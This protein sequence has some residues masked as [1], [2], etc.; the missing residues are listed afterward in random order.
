M[1][2]LV[3]GRNENVGAWIAVG[4]LGSV[5]AVISSYK[6]KFISKK[7]L[8]AFVLLFVWLASAVVGLGI[9]KQHIYDHYFG[10]FFPVPFLI[11]GGVFQL[12]LN[13]AFI[14]GWWVVGTAL[15]YLVYFN[16]ADSPLRYQP[17]RQLQRS[18][19]VAEFVNEK[20]MGKPFNFAVI[21]ERNYEAAYQYFFEKD[22]SQLVLI[23]PQ[24]TDETITDQ[25][26][27]V[28]ELENKDQ[29]DPTHNSKAEVANFGWSKIEEQWDI[30]G[31]RVYKLVHTQP[32][33]EEVLQ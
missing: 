13:R 5:L 29:C 24:N 7:V 3:G 21:A 22:N 28:C 20:S 15:V 10:F 17:N 1:T 32:T 16:F 8:H 31:V 27:V 11:I 12:L 19:I 2:R 25:L 14:R 18:E 30:E 6:K 26:M 33:N 23:D 9:Y 4:I